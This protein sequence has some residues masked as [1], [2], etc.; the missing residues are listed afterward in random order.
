MYVLLLKPR[1]LSHFLKTKLCSVN[2]GRGNEAR[3]PV[4]RW[5]HFLLSCYSPQESTTETLSVGLS[6]IPSSKCF[7]YIPAAIKENQYNLLAA[8]R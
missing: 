4:Q 1:A 5:G 3:K 6:V 7:W 8:E 2:L